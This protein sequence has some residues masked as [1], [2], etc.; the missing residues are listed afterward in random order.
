MVVHRVRVDGLGAEHRRQMWRLY[1]A[2]YDNVSHDVFERDLAEKDFVF[3]AFDRADRLHVAVKG[4]STAM[5]YEHSYRGETVG[6]LFSG[7][8]IIDPEYWGQTALHRAFLATGVRW[9]LDNPGRRLYWLLIC[10]GCRTYL[11]MARNFPEHWPHYRR[12]LPDWERGLID[13][14]ARSKF[15][16]SW[17][18]ERGVVAVDAAQPKL[19]DHVA[20]FT[21]DVR[22]M[23]EIRFFERVN[24]GHDRGDELAMLGLVDLG[25]AMR[26]GWKLARRWLPWRG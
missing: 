1:E 17:R 20:P 21:D 7:D 24:P 26:F 13:S 10:S 19:K 6:V 12:G 16:A 15:G 4:F 8:T 3:L 22:A 2:Y 14:I 5:V 23:P 25:L 9:K 18:P 11:T